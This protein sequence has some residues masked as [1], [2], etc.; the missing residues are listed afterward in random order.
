MRPLSVAIITYNEESNIERC[1]SSVAGLADEIVVV[2]S[3]STDRTRDICEK[4]NV[5]FV[6]HR[7]EGYIEQKNFA[8]AQ[9]TH[10]FVLLLDADE[11]LSPQL[12]NTVSAQKENDFPYVAY[13]MNRCTN[14]CGKFIRHGLWYP[15]RKLRLFNKQYGRWGGINPHDKIELQAAYTVKWLKGDLFHYSYNSV[16]EHA[17]QNERFS[18][19]SA[20]A[21]YRQGKKNGLV[22]LMFS[23][24]WAFLNGY[25]FRLG[26]LDGYA[27]WVVAV[28]TAQLTYLKYRKLQLRYFANKAKS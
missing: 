4:Y 21:L 19:I 27:G 20:D 9:T 2:D 23:P 13:S 6:Q 3:F 28:K 8:L 7:F 17:A 18:T 16:E 12:F 14:Y 5:T 25:L 15:D 24:L 10:D 1:L 11:A 26:F 22:K